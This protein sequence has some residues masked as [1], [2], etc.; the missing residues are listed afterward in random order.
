[1]RLAIAVLVAISLA[2]SS[3]VLAEEQPAAKAAADAACHCR[4]CDPSVCCKV[5]TGFAPLDQKCGSSCREEHWA[6]GDGGKC[7]PRADCCR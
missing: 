6:A 3:A 1:M 7:E 5:P 4:V 2:R